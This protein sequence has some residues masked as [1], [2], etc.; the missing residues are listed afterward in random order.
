MVQS[1]SKT[2]AT[3]EIKGSKECPFCGHGKTRIFSSALS[4]LRCVSC[5]LLFRDISL[6]ETIMINRNAWSD[7]YNHK[8]ETGATDLRL[9]RIYAGNL[10]SSLGLKSIKGL[11]IL[12]FGTGRGDMLVALSELGADVYGVEPFGYE[13]LKSRGFKV[14]HEI[15]AIPKGF[16][17]DGIIANDVIEHVFF[18]WD[19]VEKLYGLLNVSGWLYIAT[20]NAG[21]FNA[22][23]F[24]AH[25]RELYNQGHIRF[26]NSACLEGIFTK[27]GIVEFKRL[28]WFIKYSNNPLKALVNYF[29]QF[30]K[31]D[32]VLRYVLLRGAR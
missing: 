20:P 30:F 17:F 8:N 26:F 10:I 3:N 22:S 5:G 29:L 21:G 19:V 6:S 15:D 27:L 4:M 12:D 31:L 24:K 18:P 2:V 25:W 7:L 14:F 16:L 1:C 28:S 32:G 9:S 11:K 23:F 13:H